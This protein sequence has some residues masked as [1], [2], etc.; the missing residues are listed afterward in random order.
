[1][2]LNIIMMAVLLG[3]FNSGIYATGTLQSSSSATNSSDTLSSS[4]TQAVSVQDTTGNKRTVLSHSDSLSLGAALGKKYFYGQ[5]ADINVLKAK[6]YYR[7]ASKGN[8]AAAMN[9]LG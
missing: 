2:K 8:S 3:C 6:E 1:M 7:Q 4:A 9:R 5:N